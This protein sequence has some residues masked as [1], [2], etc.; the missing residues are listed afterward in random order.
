MK[1]KA[2]VIPAIIPD[3]KQTARQLAEYILSLSRTI[4]EPENIPVTRPTSAL[5]L[6]PNAPNVVFLSDLQP[7]EIVRVISFWLES[8]MVPRT[9]SRL[10]ADKEVLE[11]IALNNSMVGEI[12]LN[13]H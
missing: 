1:N 8:G 7:A 3:Y 2:D 12:N 10:E 11:T 13:G 9:C 4:S 5:L 6:N